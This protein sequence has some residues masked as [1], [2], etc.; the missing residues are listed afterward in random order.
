M[1]GCIW[2]QH[3]IMF[4]GTMLIFWCFPCVQMLLRWSH[5][6]CWEAFKGAVRKNWPLVPFLLK[7]N[8][9]HFT[10]VTA[11]CAYQMTGAAVASV[12]FFSQHHPFLLKGSS[13]FFSISRSRVR[14][15][16]EIVMSPETQLTWWF[17]PVSTDLTGIWGSLPQNPCVVLTLRNFQLPIS[18][19]SR[20]WD[21]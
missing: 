1:W 9:A 5:F 14:C 12:A 3:A 16:V 19:A 10:R 11:N 13:G 15:V 2:A 18:E 17:W 4:T 6:L 21:V 7:I 20:R 8:R